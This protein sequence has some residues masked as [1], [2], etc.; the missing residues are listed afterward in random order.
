MYVITNFYDDF[1]HNNFGLLVFLVY[2]FCLLHIASKQKLAAIDSAR[3][4]TIYI[5]VGVTMCSY[6]HTAQLS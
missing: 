4:E 6:E 1:F 3:P 5:H 2:L